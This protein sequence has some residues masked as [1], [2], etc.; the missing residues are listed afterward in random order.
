M[1]CPGAH[2]DFSVGPP[3]CSRLLHQLKCYFCVLAVLKA[4]VG[5]EETSPEPLHVN[6][7]DWAPKPTVMTLALAAEATCD[8]DADGVVV[9]RCCPAALQPGSVEGRGSAREAFFLSAQ[10]G[11]T[12]SISII[13]AATKPL[14]NSAASAHSSV[15]TLALHSRFVVFLH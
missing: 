11:L 14:S 1:L 13:T 8:D 15:S 9:A 4:E 10:S 3:L 12:T 5:V 2:S 7:L 6:V